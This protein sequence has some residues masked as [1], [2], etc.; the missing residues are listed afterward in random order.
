[1]CHAPL[2]IQQ[3]IMMTVQQIDQQLIWVVESLPLISASITGNE[4]VDE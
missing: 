1:M 4:A 3:T 2:I